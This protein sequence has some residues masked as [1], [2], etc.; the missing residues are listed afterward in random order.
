MIKFDFLNYVLYGCV[1]VFR[2]Q[3]HLGTFVVLVS[4]FLVSFQTV[5]CWDDYEMDLFD[6]VE[7]INMNFYD[8]LGVT[9]VI[10]II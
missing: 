1:I 2:M 3:L 4:I 9:Q 6:L 8:Y 10:R 5:N 7:E